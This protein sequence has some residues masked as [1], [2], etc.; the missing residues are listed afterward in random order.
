MT[1]VLK[2]LIETG[3]NTVI[4]AAEAVALTATEIAEEVITS[5]LEWIEE[6]ISD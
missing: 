3:Q 2:K 6:S 5:A 4:P 1:N